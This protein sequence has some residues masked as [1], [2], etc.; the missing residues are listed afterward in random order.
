MPQTIEVTLNGRRV[1]PRPRRV[2]AD[3]RWISDELASV[4]KALDYGSS[5]AV[6]IK[7]AAR[8]AQ[9]SHWVEKLY[10]TGKYAC[11]Q[12]VTV[13]TTGRP[14]TKRPKSAE[15]YGAEGLPVVFIDREVRCRQCDNCLKARSALWRIR[16]QAEIE[17]AT[18]V[19]GR[20]WFGTLTLSP[21]Q[22]SRVG[23]ACRLA[24]SRNGDDFDLFSEERQFRERH[25]CIS[26]EITLYAKRLRKQSGASVKFLCVVEAHK[27]GLPHYHMLVHEQLPVPPVTHRVLK[28]QWRVGFSNWKL[29][30]G[31]AMAGYV[32]KYLSKSA[33]ARVRASKD[34]GITALAIAFKEGVSSMPYN[35]D[36]G[37]S[38]EEPPASPILT[39]LEKAMND[40]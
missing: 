21:E 24:A 5:S 17:R 18:L 15:T 23:N 16:A 4:R 14:L 30:T 20:S 36:G 8:R 11:S 22:H 25:A 9:P 35:G 26:R 10:G 34:Y 37:S 3:Q 12:P 13:E 27:S 40:V 39:A 29:V 28:T 7:F 31:P 33:L 32:T 19:G 38:Q 2:S 1:K 6:P